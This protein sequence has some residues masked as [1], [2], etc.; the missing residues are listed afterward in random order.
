MVGSTAATPIER[1]RHGATIATDGERT[2]RNIA[3]RAEPA[4]PSDDVPPPWAATSPPGL[5]DAW[6][7]A[8]LA[9]AVGSPAA[10][11]PGVACDERRTELVSG[12]AAAVFDD[13][14]AAGLSAELAGAEPMVVLVVVADVAED[15]AVV[16]PR[17]PAELGVDVAVVA[18]VRAGAGTDS[19]G[20]VAPATT[21][22]VGSAIDVGAGAALPSAA[23]AAGVVV[24]REAEAGAGFDTDDGAGAVASAETWALAAVAA[25]TALAGRAAGVLAAGFATA[26]MPMAAKARCTVSSVPK[27]LAP[28]AVTAAW[29]LVGKLISML[30]LVSAAGVMALSVWA[31]DLDTAWATAVK[32]CCRIGGAAL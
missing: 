20:A 8:P 19:A 7:T 21:P 30:M 29:G 31:A 25:I 17:L 28:S 27:K 32:T 16:D 12:A 14:G 22:A 3:Q 1:H 10:A 2:E 4:V 15:A 24:L 18:A 5:S 6:P 26:P 13:V 9:A 23:G 11:L